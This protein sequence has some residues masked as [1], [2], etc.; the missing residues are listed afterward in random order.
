MNISKTARGCISSGPSREPALD[1]ALRIVRDLPARGMY[2]SRA[3]AYTLGG[4]KESDAKAARLFMPSFLA[5]AEEIDD[6]TRWAECMP[7][8]AEALTD[9]DDVGDLL[10]IAD[11][12]DTSVA[13]FGL[14]DVRRW[15]CLH[16]EVLVLMALA[17][18]QAK[19]GNREA[20]VATF[21][22][23]ESL[24]AMPAGEGESFRSGRLS[25]LARDRV[26][27]GDVEG[28]IRTT[29]LIVYEYYKAI[30][31][32]QIAE[33]QANAGHRVEART[34][35]S[36][37][38][39][40]AREIKIRDPSRDRPGSFILDAS[41]CLRTIAYVQAKAGFSDDALLTADSINEP[42]R[43]NSALALIAPCMAQQGQIKPA[44]ELAQKIIDE[45]AK[46]AALEGIALAQS[47]SGDLSGALEWVRSRKTPEARAN[48]LLGVV[49]AIGKR[50]RE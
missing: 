22:K 36:R 6:G 43:R 7:F 32:M 2:R 38:I 17:K 16:S 29:G 33:N 18:A 40:T 35:F 15:N 3:L 10:R 42:N 28:A 13:E 23:A 49:L 4:L 45:K 14:A 12:L 11:K 26:G 39:Q 27:T 41:E 50:E 44:L 46:N 31:L 25:R 21:N 19:A 8:L 30:A 34:L 24:A 1:E 47:V 20:A 48:A 9:A 5:M 37:A